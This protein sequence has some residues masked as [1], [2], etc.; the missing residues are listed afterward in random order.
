MSEGLCCINTSVTWQAV[1]WPR[2]RWCLHRY[3]IA[4]NCGNPV[5]THARSARVAVGFGW[6]LLLVF[7]VSIAVGLVYT[8]VVRGLWAHRGQ[9]GAHDGGRNRVERN[10]GQH[11]TATAFWR[12]NSAASTFAPASYVVG[13]CVACVL[14]LYTWLTRS[15][16]YVLC[17][18]A[19]AGGCGA[20]GPRHAPGGRPAHNPLHVSGPPHG[21][22]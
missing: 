13:I 20:A 18:A 11:R 9:D 2:C 19:A 3:C 21:T 8:F 15:C 14:A 4:T 7:L 16:A 22:A 1:L 12:P 6:Q 10:P 17:A 5:N